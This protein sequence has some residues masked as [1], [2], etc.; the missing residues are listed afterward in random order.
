MRFG[1]QKNRLIERVILS[2]HSICFGWEIIKIILAD[3]CWYIKGQDP[4]VSIFNNE[5]N[6]H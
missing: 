2:T 3:I 4:I 1:A 5:L 6:H